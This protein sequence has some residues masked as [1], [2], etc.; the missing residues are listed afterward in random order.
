MAEDAPQQDEILSP[1]EA[2]AWLDD[3]L[4]QQQEG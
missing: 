2:R 4:K 1:E 3:F